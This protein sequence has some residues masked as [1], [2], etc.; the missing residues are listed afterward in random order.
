MPRPA[1]APC[2]ACLLLA[3]LASGCRTSTP[4]PLPDAAPV[5]GLQLFANPSRLVIRPGSSGRIRFE[6]R[7]QASQPVPDYA[8]EFSIPSPTGDTAFAKLGTQRLLTDAQGAAVLEIIVG[9]LASNDRPAEFWVVATC[10]DAAPARALITVTTNAYSV[11]VLPMPAEDLLGATILSRNRVLFFDNSACSNIDLYHVL[12]NASQARAAEAN[13]GATVLFAGVAASGVHAVVGLGLD[14][15]G[16]VRAG[17]CV[18]VPGAALPDDVTMRV[19]LVLDHL[20]PSLSGSYEVVSDFRLNPAPTGLGTIRSAWQQW[21]RCPL[22]PARLWLDCTIAAMDPKAK[23]CVPD[24]GS[25][26]PLATRLLAGR[27]TPT[28]LPSGTTCRAAT[29]SNGNPS[30]DSVVDGLFAD[31]RSQLATLSGFPAELATLLSEIRLTSRMAFS[32]TNEAN[33]YRVEHEL[34]TV[35]FPAISASFGVR[36]TLALPVTKASAIRATFKGD[37]VSLPDHGFTLRL[38]TI[39]RY[40]FEASSLAVRNARDSPGLVQA[41]FGLAQWQ[42]ASSTL[43]GCEALDA[44]ACDQVGQPRKCLLDA[45][46]L[47]MDALAATLADSFAVLDGEGID[48]R[49]QGS[50]PVIDLNTDGQA[51][52]LGV[53]LCWAVVSDRSVPSG[54]YVMDG[55]W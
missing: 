46:R 30:L 26:G 50:A 47:G 45:C 19:L 18:D 9:A 35:A 27:G 17:G 23:R 4:V 54:N 44:V 55:Y 21:S 1:A 31:R 53:G 24:V 36:T 41:I 8:L 5:S 7:D 43:N 2:Q 12:D 28:T 13:A 38:G 25:A 11:E 29:D 51:D 20:F 22:D 37:Q 33:T 15:A 39:S 40:A 34:L 14:S 32:R 42:D 52:A 3:L 48:F 10:L 16:V 49:L 6:L